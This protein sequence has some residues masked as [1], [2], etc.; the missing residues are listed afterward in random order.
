MMPLKV[1]VAPQCPYGGY[2]EQDTIKHDGVWADLAKRCWGSPS[3][4]RM[5]IEAEKAGV[6]VNPYKGAFCRGLFDAGRAHMR[7]KNEPTEAGG[8]CK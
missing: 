1:Q 7:K 2:A 8:G 4:Y 3:A 5:G 6:E